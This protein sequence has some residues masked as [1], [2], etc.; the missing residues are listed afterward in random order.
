M[1]TRI[2]RFLAP[3]VFIGLIGA[4]LWYLWQYQAN[5]NLPA[6][7]REEIAAG[8][9]VEESIDGFVRVGEQTFLVEI[10]DTPESR[11]QGL[12]FREDLPLDQGMLF[13]FPESKPY[14][15]WMPNLA[16][17]LDIVWIDSFQNIVDVKTV[18]PCQKEVISECPS[19]QPKGA[20]KYVLEVNANA[21]F[22]QVGDRVEFGF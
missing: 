7:E 14:E 17:P 6:T 15:F 22:G 8:I 13:I 2:L 3:F 4:L 10:A 18:P 12:M 11:T 16:F 5:Q 20:A 19:Y 21:F 1:I 9:E